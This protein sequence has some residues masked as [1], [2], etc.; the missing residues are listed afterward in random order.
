MNQT[1]PTID[2]ENLMRETRPRTPSRR[3]FHSPEIDGISLPVVVLDGARPGPTVCVSAGVHGSEYC[4]LEVAQR[5]LALDPAEVSGRIIVLPLVNIPAFIGRAAY[6]NPTDGINPNRAFPGRADGSQSYRLTHWLTYGI[7]RH[8]D[9][10]IDLHSGD[11]SEYVRPFAIFLRDDPRTRA[12][13]RAARLE[14]SIGLGPGGMS[15]HGAAAVGVPGVILEAGGAL[16][17]GADVVGILHSGLLRALAFTGAIRLSDDEEA[18]AGAG[19]DTLIEAPAAIIA[20]QD[21]LWYPENEV[22]AIL[23]E[24]AVVGR[25][26]DYF[27]YEKTAIH[28]PQSGALLYQLVGMPVNAEEILCWIGDK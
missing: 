28:A 22:G 27:G 26:R 13:A 8:C 4:A 24:G 2:L 11:L 21:G 7:F 18:T 6:V 25:I 14:F 23:E 16:S 1:Y 12:L 20:T 19:D 5:L 3:D 10:L 15:L 17:R 9:F